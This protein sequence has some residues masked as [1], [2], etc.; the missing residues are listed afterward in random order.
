MVGHQRNRAMDWGSWT[1]G[2]LRLRAEAVD[3]TSLRHGAARI[4][5]GSRAFRLCGRGPMP[6][7]LGVRGGMLRLAAREGAGPEEMVT[8]MFWYGGAG[9]GGKPG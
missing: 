9:R 7:S 4:P 8:M 2:T 6:L 5:L 3:E 1:Q